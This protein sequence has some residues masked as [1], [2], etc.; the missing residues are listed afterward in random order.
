MLTTCMHMQH[1]N[2]LL[3]HLDKKNCNIRLEQMKHL[4]IH[5]NYTCITITTCATTRSTFATL[6]Y[7]TYNIPLKHLKH[8]K[9]NLA[10]HVL[11][12]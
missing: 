5:L 8:L 10:I 3:Q 2:L 7:N 12:V 4:E 6:I 1:P 9:H 11:S